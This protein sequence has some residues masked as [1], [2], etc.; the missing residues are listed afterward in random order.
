MR[1][2]TI[3]FISAIFVV[4]AVFSGCGGQSGGVVKLDPDNPV[5]IT[6]WHYYNGAQ[7][8]AFDELVSEFN[9]T[10]GKE[11]GI[12]VE[13]YSQ[14]SVADLEK[15]V[16]DAVAEKIGADPL[17]DMF[18]TYA[19]TAY[20]V[21]QQGKLTD[22]TEYFSEKELGEYVEPYIE[23]G[24]FNGDGAVYLFPIAK[25]TETMMINK[26]D[27]DKFAAASGTDIS[28]LS[29][30]EGV[31]RVAKRYYEWTDSLTP[32]TPGDGKAFYGRDSMSNY[33]VIGMRQMGVDI[34]DVEN[35]DVKVNVDKDKI[36]RLWDN[37]YVP[38]VEGYFAGPG[39][40]RSDDI[41][42]GDIIAYTGSVSS[43][44]YFPDRVE[45]D[46][47]AVD[48]DYMVIHAPIMEGGENISVQQGA[49]MAV[50]RSDAQHEYA[51]C[52][53]LRW[54]TAKDNNLRF[55]CDS[56]Y[57]PVR[58]DANSVEALDNIIAEDNIE[59]DGK[60]YDCLVNI[61]DDYSSMNFYTT[62]CFVNGYAS[63]TILDYDLSDKA[64][65]DIKAIMKVVAAGTP[66][67]K[68]AA[69]YITD[70]AFDEWYEGFC[71]K[72]EAVAYA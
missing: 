29:T 14:G 54:F 18:S 72:L 63:R 62:K 37:Y 9:A 11:K 57:L 38:M 51:S 36:K 55:V 30:T 25:S 39:K 53:F 31:V 17:P 28:E 27:W 19:D 61:L 52:E 71:K 41:K 32:D 46:S 24:D 3:A 69:A 42:T 43:S 21:Q 20:A 6:I 5:S 23:E 1:R 56:G 40:F 66:R 7:Q 67:H 35:G 33:F 44:M 4:L 13:G 65:D 49:G 16:S 2:R 59:I 10:E 48:I 64:S 60:V 34:F 12:Y 26:T 22:L 58:S 50:T 47:G 8:A 15:A 45:L 68:A 70:E